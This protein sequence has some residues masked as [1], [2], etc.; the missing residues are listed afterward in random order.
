MAIAKC[1]EYTET[2]RRHNDYT[3]VRRANN[4][5]YKDGKAIKITQYELKDVI[6]NATAG[7]I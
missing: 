4:R 2:H 3:T 1:G 7:D 5:K 6:K